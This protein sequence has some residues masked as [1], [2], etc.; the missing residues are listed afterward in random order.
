[1]PETN[2]NTADLIA[3]LPTLLGAGVQ[4]SAEAARQL[5]DALQPVEAMPGVALL[6]LD[7]AR[8]DS[9][10]I[11][12]PA[13]H[14]LVVSINPADPGGGGATLYAGDQRAIESVL[15]LVENAQR[16]RDAPTTSKL[17]AARDAGSGRF[18]LIGGLGALITHT[19]GV[20]FRAPGRMFGR[21]ADFRP[22]AQSTP[23][24]GDASLY[25]HDEMGADTDIKIAPGDVGY[26]DSLLTTHVDNAAAY[27]N[28]VR[29]T[30]GDQVALELEAGRLSDDSRDI[31][32]H[33]VEHDPALRESMSRY[34]ASAQALADGLERLDPAQLIENGLGKHDAFDIMDMI[35]RKKSLMKMPVLEN[36]QV[37]ETES[38][39]EK[40]RDFA[41]RL[42]DMIKSVIKPVIAMGHGAGQGVTA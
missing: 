23:F 19:M 10:G 29:S 41:R 12:G 14:A 7:A 21:G 28:Q 9:L 2:L 38:V 42:V 6:S 35:E 8:R 20:M 33:S 24:K 11:H 22:R 37:V 40:L 31:L 27:A 1:M 34:R 3:S 5:R 16:H 4:I 26:F 32:A 39:F 36:G 15:D 25:V 17:R 18:D 30:A 13:T